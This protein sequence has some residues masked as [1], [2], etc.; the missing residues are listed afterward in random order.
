MSTTKVLGVALAG[1][2]TLAALYLLGAWLRLYGSLESAGEPTA[3]PVSAEI[4]AERQRSQQRASASLSSAPAK[5]ILFGD[6]HVHSTY[7]TDAFLWSL[8]MVQG[9]GAH[10][11]ADACD[12][13]RLCSGLDFW[14]I[15]DHAEASTP[16]KWSETKRAIRECQAI[17]GDEANPDVAMP[18][19]PIARAGTSSSSSPRK[20]TFLCP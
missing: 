19:A 16:R 13:A 9:D 4:L 1:V 14:S 3:A 8:P 17:A 7:S 18:A 5:Q 12:Y 2:V 6:L 20:I 10:P 11:I 15:N